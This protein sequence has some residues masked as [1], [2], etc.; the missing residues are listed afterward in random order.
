M[1]LN[2]KV[3]KYFF[4]IC[5]RFYTF[6]P[7]FLLISPV[8]TCVRFI[9]VITQFQPYHDFFKRIKGLLLYL[10]FIAYKEQMHLA[11]SKIS[12]EVAQMASQV[13]I[14]CFEVLP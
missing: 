13:L 4:W 8:Y 1:L 12:H 3:L 11:L 14:F 6:I 7:L 5:W 2:F 10:I 9:K